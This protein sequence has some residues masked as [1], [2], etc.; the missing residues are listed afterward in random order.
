MK[1]PDLL[2]VG[3]SCVDA[4]YID[5][6]FAEKDVVFTTPT[7]GWK[8]AADKHG[9]GDAILVAEY[10]LVR[11]LAVAKVQPE[12]IYSAKEVTAL[13]LTVPAG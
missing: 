13:A 10:R 12:P 2:Y 1:M 7:T 11:L 9:R 5:A 6:D 4:D 3:L 8:E